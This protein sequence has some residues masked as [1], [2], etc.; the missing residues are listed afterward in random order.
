MEK[1]L[2]I[3]AFYLNVE[4]MSR[5]SIVN[6]IK[7]YEGIYNKQYE[8]INKEVIIHIIPVSKKETQLECI[9]PPPSV[10]NKDLL[11]NELL[12][13][14]KLI[15]NEKNDEAKKIVRNIER[16]LKLNKLKK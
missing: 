12:K 10:S 8:N 6:T 9:Y 11:E 1:D 4:S 5:T 2:I 13:I 14:Y 15:V 3:L 16:K 7:R